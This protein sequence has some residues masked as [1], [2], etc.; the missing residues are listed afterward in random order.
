MI[1]IC[2][3][4]LTGPEARSAGM[5]PSLIRAGGGSASNSTLHPNPRHYTP[6]CIARPIQSSHCKSLANTFREMRVAGLW[7]APY[8]LQHTPH[9]FLFLW[10]PF[11]IQEVF[12]Q[13]C[14]VTSTSLIMKFDVFEC[15]KSLATDVVTVR[16]VVSLPPPAKKF[17]IT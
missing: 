7:R 8:K 6:F 2:V 4:H 14:V 9:N 3:Q 1:P 5:T 16:A 13:F 10:A 17:D 15:L 11:L 12:C